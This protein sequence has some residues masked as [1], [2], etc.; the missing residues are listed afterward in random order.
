MTMVYCLHQC[1]FKRKHYLGPEV[2]GLRS[3]LGQT[4]CLV[5]FLRRPLFA[6]DR[7]PDRSYGLV[8]LTVWSQ[9]YS[10]GPESLPGNPILELA[11]T[12]DLPTP[13]SR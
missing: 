9:L 11:R 2:H 5:Y 6:G 7:S 12:L 8:R 10:A 13:N 3:S 1:V 4:A